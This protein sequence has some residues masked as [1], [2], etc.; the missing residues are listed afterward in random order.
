MSSLTL[1]ISPA[2]QLGTTRKARL[3]ISLGLAGLLVGWL[4]GQ[5]AAA[6]KGVD[7]VGLAIVLV[8]VA[9]WKRPQIAPLVLLAAALLIEQVAPGVSPTGVNEPGVGT[10]VMT[11]HIP[12][13]SSIPLFRGIGSLHME[14]VDLLL[15]AIFVIYLVKSLEWGPRWRPNSHVSVAVSALI[16]T[17]VLGLVVGISSHGDFRVA[18]MEARPF[19]YLGSSY[20]LTA[21]LI[22][23]RTTLHAALWMIV[24]VIGLKAVQGLYVFIQIRHVH[25]RPEAVL[26]HEEAYS[27]AIFIVLVAALWLFQV[28]GPLMK[29]A[30]WLLP[31]VITADLANNRRAAWLLLGGGLITL[32]AVGYRSLPARRRVLGR[33]TVVVLAVSAVYLPAYWN[34]TGGLAQPAR[35]I[36]SVISPD[37]RDA[38]SDLYRIQENANLQYNIKKHGG[39]LGVGFGVPIDYALPIVNIKSIDPLIAYIPHNGV[40]YIL[41]RMGLLGGIAMWSVIGTGIVAG[42]RLARA[43]DREI[44]VIG[45]LVACALV[46]YALEGATD[47]GFFFYRIAF[48]TGGLLGLAEAARRIARSGGRGTIPA[49]VPAEGTP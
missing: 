1:P 31:V 39:L 12:I 7:I 11:A 26:G 37:P 35:A 14:P 17:M 24:I 8:P 5:L 42:C 23:S 32:L 48:I 47:Q 40:F 25:P 13:T 28:R 45:A 19:V 46:A 41:M 9:M 2:G 10:V 15:A 33:T 49:T 22:R 27:F 43:K 21:V 34:K 29:T 16:G 44:A 36:H 3:V 18:L 30:T 20:F 6:G 38:S 4:A